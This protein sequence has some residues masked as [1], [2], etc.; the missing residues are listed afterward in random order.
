MNEVVEDLGQEPTCAR[1]HE[2]DAPLVVEH[3]CGEGCEGEDSA[4]EGHAEK[5]YEPKG[6]RELLDI[7][8]DDLVAALRFRKLE[9]FLPMVVH[10]NVDQVAQQGEQAEARRSPESHAVAA[11]V[12]RDEFLGI[13][14]E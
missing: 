6:G 3:V 10:G 4:V 7:R 14:A 13:E 5:D 11:E 9:H 2:R 8:E 1:T 12:A